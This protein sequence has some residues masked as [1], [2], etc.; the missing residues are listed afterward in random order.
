MVQVFASI[1]SQKQAELQLKPIEVGDWTHT[2]AKR[3]R[4][5]CRH[6]QKSLSR[7]CTSAWAVELRQQLGISTAPQGFQ[8]QF[9]VNSERLW[10]ASAF[11]VCLIATVVVLA[12]VERFLALL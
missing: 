6:A 3:I 1:H 9:V 5:M 2:M 8:M 4:H 12:G 10:P 11:D 7:S